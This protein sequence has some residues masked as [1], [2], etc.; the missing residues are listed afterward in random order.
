M[1]LVWDLAFCSDSSHKHVCNI[2]GMVD[3][4]HTSANEKQMCSEPV[5]EMSSRKTLGLP[6]E[7]ARSGLLEKTS[8]NH[9]I[10]GQAQL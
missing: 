6:G 1:F 4:F 7:K 2:V 3:D 10:H 9:S 5:Q 8:R